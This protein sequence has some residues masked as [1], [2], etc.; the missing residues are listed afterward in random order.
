MAPPLN[1]KYPTP[2]RSKQ[3]LNHVKDE[4]GILDIGW[5]EG[6]LADGRAYRAEM[7]A[8]DGVSMLTFFFSSAEI[9]DLD[10]DQL[11]ERVVAE[12]LV[13]FKPGAREICGAKLC[14]DDADEPMWSINVFVGAEDESCLAGSV[15]IWPYAGK[16]EANSIFHPLV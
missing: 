15:P 8:Q 6:V 4:D 12:G 14:A 7:W 13:A 5:S 2:N 3:T 10:Q 16:G 9:A 11:K 1:P